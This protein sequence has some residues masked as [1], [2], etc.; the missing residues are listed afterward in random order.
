MR[1]SLG[2]DG[3]NGNQGRGASEKKSKLRN[4]ILCEAKRNTSTLSDCPP[5]PSKVS[6]SNSSPRTEGREIYF[7]FL[8]PSATII[9]FS[10]FLVF[11]FQIF[12]TSIS[13][14]LGETL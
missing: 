2:C 1:E 14:I 12:D 7:K 4:S 3:R 5:R 8:F 9:Y 11:L 6:K 13:S 10:A